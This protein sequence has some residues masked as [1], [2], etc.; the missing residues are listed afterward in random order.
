MTFIQNDA[1]IEAFPP[2]GADHSFADRIHHRCLSSGDDFFDIHRA[3]AIL[4][5]ALKFRVAIVNEELRRGII[6]KRIGQ[7]L[8]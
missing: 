1:V 2:E 8:S 7:L 5:R 4:K 6:W 3:G